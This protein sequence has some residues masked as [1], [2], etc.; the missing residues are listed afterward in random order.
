MPKHANIRIRLQSKNKFL[1]MEDS[2]GKPLLYV[3][4]Y[5]RR[6]YKAWCRCLSP[7][8]YCFY[9]A[10]NSRIFDEVD[11]LLISERHKCR[12]ITKIIGWRICMFQ[13]VI[14]NPARSL[15]LLSMR[16]LYALFNKYNRPQY[17]IR[18]I[19]RLDFDIMFCGHAGV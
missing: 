5:C 18:Y 12:V 4:K 1:F 16:C 3:K 14:I 2:I 8:G 6:K 19:L 9:Y 17:F 13:P 11:A 15:K 7:I 10:L